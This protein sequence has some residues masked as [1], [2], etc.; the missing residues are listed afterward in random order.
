MDVLIGM[1]AFRAV[2]ASGSFARASR[3]LAVSTAWTSKLVSQLEEH[4]GAQLL[5]R[6]TRRLSLTDAGRLYL[7]RCQR[8]LDDLDEAERSIGHLQ[9]APRGR[10]R[11]NAPMSFGLLRLA[12]IL[13][14]FC[15]QFPE[16]ELD[17]S[18]NDRRVDLLDEGVDVAVRIGEKLED[19]T[20]TAR[21]IGT[22]SR[23]VCAAPAYLRARGTP[24][25]PSELSE[26]ACLRF[27]LHATPDVWTF[28]G[29]EGPHA[30]SVRGPLQSDNSI[31]LRDAALAGLGVLLT[32]DFIVA[33]ALRRKRL[34][35]LLAAFAPSGYGV[36]AVSPPARYA[37]PKVHA[38]VDFLRRAL[39]RSARA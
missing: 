32:P 35:P 13:P 24:R 39:A 26:H 7:E 20:L 29:P 34:R 14:S 3:S 9:G 31:A 5:V 30:I 4:L 22:G 11:V 1:R 21:K 37:T 28:G 18:L 10:L 2:V 36:F 17:L 19:S 8:L 25:H 12:P 23:V 38:F 27:G 15:K 6:T 16:V 33:D